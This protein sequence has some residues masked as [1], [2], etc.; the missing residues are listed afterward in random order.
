M[1]DDLPP[2][3]TPALSPLPAET[4][5]V[6]PAT[7]GLAPNVAAGIAAIFTLLG[8]IVM[9]ALEKRDPFVRFW[10]MQSVFFG[11]ATLVFAIAAAVI[12][13]VLGSISAPLGWLWSLATGAVDIGLVVVWII[14]VIKAFS[15]KE[16]E[17]PV[18]GKLARQQ[19]TPSTTIV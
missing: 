13:M 7:T 5:P 1:P 15:G 17:I 11:G 10:A 16:W 19:L 18:L 8:G 12:G 14:T 9:L 4:S 2:P 6:V 3:V